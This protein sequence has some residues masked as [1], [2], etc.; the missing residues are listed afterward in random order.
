M[1][2]IIQ[3]LFRV[4]FICL[5]SLLVLELGFQITHYF[6]F[7]NQQEISKKVF[8]QNEIRILC[9]GESITSGVPEN[10]PNSYP[11]LLEVKLKA[12]YPELNF[13]VINRGMA[14]VRTSFILNSLPEWLEKDHPQ[15]V[16]SMLGLGDRFF[17]NEVFSFTFS[18]FWMELLQKSRVFR[19]MNLLS[20]VLLNQFNFY[21]KAPPWETNLEEDNVYRESFRKASVAFNQGDLDMALKLF[22]DFALQM[23]DRRTRQGSNNNSQKY[24]LKI[25]ESLIDH[26]YSSLSSILL[27]HSLK[28][29]LIQ[30]EPTI[31][32]AL[33]LDPK[34]PF[35]HFM[36]S[37]FYFDLG[38]SLKGEKYKTSADL[39]MD[40]YVLK[41][42]QENY[43]AINKLLQEKKI[44]HVAM[45]YPLRPLEYLKV[46][47][48]SDDKIYFVE[49]KNSFRK[50]VNDKTYYTYF[51]DICG[52]S[53][54]HGTTLGNSMI[55]Q[56]LIDQ[57]FDVFLSQ[58]S[59]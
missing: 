35:L 55:V 32:H 19:F 38:D 14:G 23:Q 39:L 56:N 34:S 31:L 13:R 46:I 27:I 52:G 24:Y 54:G 50:L 9:I 1:K 49:N 47:L 43:R 30:A 37:R 41:S 17:T 36:V 7:R 11:R 4:A 10:A 2:K 5:I 44:V 6:F 58:T 57:F 18:P 12:L 29:T 33:E 40:K 8:A 45:Q 25:P 16:I 51:T 42:S 21:E 26:Y 53:F 48:G 59:R 15:I 3:N 28:K 20:N 22:K